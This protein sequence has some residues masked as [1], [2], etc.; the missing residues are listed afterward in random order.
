MI[1]R[2]LRLAAT[3]LWRSPR[4]SILTAAG[5]AN[6]VAGG[7]MFYGFTRDTYW[8]LAESFAR[9]GNGHVQVADKAW[10]DSPAP[11][12]H[13]VERA[14]MEA[15]R[16][17]LEA[18]PVIAEHLNASTLRRN[19]MGMLVDSSGAS[20]V[21]LGVGTDPATEARI[22]PMAHPLRGAPLDAARPDGI[23][24]GL[25]L[26][27]R[28]GADV[29]HPLTALVTT[30]A[31]LTNGRDLT[32]TGLASTGSVDMD[33]TLVSLPLDTALALVD[34]TTVDLLVLALDDTAHTDTV[35]EAA[36]RVLADPKFAGLD[37]QPWYARAQY[38][39]A[40][41]ALYDRIFGVFEALMAL[42]T[43]LSLSHALAAVVA[44]RRAEIAML[45]VVGLRRRDVAGIFLAEGALL[46]LLGCAF[47]VVAAEGVAALVRALGGIPMPPPPGFTLTYAAQIRLD[48]LGFAIV[49]PVTFLAALGA[50]ALPAWRATRGELSRGLMGLSVLLAVTAASPQA[51]AASP[52]A[53]AP[54]SAWLLT[55]AFG[56]APPAHSRCIVDVTV[57]ESGR[58][59][60][61][62]RVAT[63][64]ADTLAVSTTLPEGRRQAVLGQSGATWF[65]TEGMAKPMRVGLAQRVMGSLSIADVIDPRQAA[66]WTATGERNGAGFTTVMAAGGP[67]VS[68]ARAEFDLD[69]SGRVTVARFYGSA[70]AP[71]RTAHYTWV[72]SA[73][74]AVQVLDAARPTAPTAM[75]VTAPRC[76]AA[77]WAVT[78]DTLMGAAQAL[79]GVTR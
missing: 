30:D 52:D 11:E 67:G 44:E 51:A 21:F 37:A 43:V 12:Q 15:A 71:L 64:D 6:A 75:A 76:A 29:G 24:V 46:G 48:A 38:Y 59:G 70:P 8:G 2:T 66:G 77:P 20:G 1:G 54:S 5:L 56:A 47:G 78:P 53:P 26:A 45:R 23:V 58:A 74:T 73:L 49:L 72:G 25:P 55:R 62:W 22:A 9:G 18:D 34:G 61:G 33:R 17:A 36:K 4:R 16:Q 32:V 79:L 7:L 3:S 10:F 63:Y 31:G 13:R 35:V 60:V 39:T 19:V 65:Q 68:Y 27:G 42:V 69:A 41:H 28:L 57:S 14:R 50:S 40:V